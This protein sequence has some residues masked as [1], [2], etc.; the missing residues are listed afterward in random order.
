MSAYSV[1]SRTGL[2]AVSAMLSTGAAAVKTF[3]LR[4]RRIE[5]RVIL[6]TADAVGRVPDAALGASFAGYLLVY[7]VMLVAYVVVLTH[8]A[9]EGAKP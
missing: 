1:T 9:R 3:T 6:R 2:F 4:G 5:T 7:S 8:L